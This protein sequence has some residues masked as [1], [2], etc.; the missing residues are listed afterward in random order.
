V[1]PLQIVS[2]APIQAPRL[3]LKT[4]VPVYAREYSRKR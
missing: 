1:I 3:D 2:G 4:P